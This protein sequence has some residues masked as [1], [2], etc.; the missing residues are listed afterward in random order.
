MNSNPRKVGIMHS[1]C[2]DDILKDVK[3]FLEDKGFEVHTEN[4]FSQYPELLGTT[5]K[6]L[7]N[8][9]LDI[10]ILW[11]TERSRSEEW[12]KK[13]LNA[14]RQCMGYCA[15]PVLL[16]NDG[17]EGLETKDFEGQEL[18]YDRNRPEVH[19]GLLLGLII[20]ELKK[21]SNPNNVIDQ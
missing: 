20:K 14:L 4:D 7:S 3:T 21:I 16:V 5:I 19:N 15:K 9:N 2:D 13:N 17:L 12:F 1:K 18:K 10:A 11:R 8:G 6:E